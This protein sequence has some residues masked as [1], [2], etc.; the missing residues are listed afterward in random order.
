MVALSAAILLVTLSVSAFYFERAQ[1]I[2]FAVAISAAA[3]LVW[4]SGWWRTHRALAAA[5]AMNVLLVFAYL[6][7]LD[8][9][10]PVTVTATPHG[11]V[12]R[13]GDNTVALAVHPQS[14]NIGLY[15]GD[16]LRAPAHPVAGG[17]GADSPLDAVASWLRFAAPQPA[18]SH[19]RLTSPAGTAAPIHPGRGWSYNRRGELESGLN[20]PPLFIAGPG[21]TYRFSVDLM[22]GDGTQG[23]LVQVA[24]HRG[25]IL[26]IRSEQDRAYWAPWNGV[27]RGRM[28]LAWTGTHVP[29]LSLSLRPMVQRALRF[30]LPSVMLA[31]A[32]LLLVAPVY[33]LVR[34]LATAPM[35]LYPG[36]RRS[37]VPAGKL[38]PPARP[39]THREMVW[40][41]DLAA[42][43]VAVW[44]L[45][46]AALIAGR[47]VQPVPN[48]QDSVA[49]LFQAKILAA[50]RLW[51]PIPR[52][53]D[54]FLQSDLLMYHGHWFGKY[55]LGWPL[56]LAVGVKLG[57]AWLVNPVL[58]AGCLLL[59]YL[60]GTLIF[61][62]VV[63]LV[64]AAFAAS[65]PFL[66]F[67][68]GTFLA[69]TAALFFFLAAVYLLVL[70]HQREG[71]SRRLEWTLRGWTFL[72]PAGLMLGVAALTRQLDTIGLALPFAVLF[73]RRP[74]A[75]GWVAIAAAAPA[76]AGLVLNRA[77][78]GGFLTNP[79]A[80]V[81]PW[82]RIGFGRGVGDPAWHVTFT[83][84]LGFWNLA[85]NLELLQSNLFGWPYYITFALIAIPFITGRAG[86][87]DLILFAS[88][89]A[90]FGIYLAYFYSGAWEG[91]P[92][93]TYGA[94]PWLALLAARGVQELYLT[95]LRL[96]L[97]RPASRLAALTLPALLSLGLLAYTWSVFL[98]AERAS[99]ASLNRD[100]GIALRVQRAHLHH[101][102]VFERT[103]THGWWRYGQLLVENGPLLSGDV[104][105]ARDLGPEDRNLMRLYPGW[106]YYRLDGTRLT[107]IKG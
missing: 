65:S 26:L 62:R 98:P 2:A 106:A 32:L 50:G 94:I 34:L 82:D 11:Y 46:V 93:Y 74:L 97:G 84:A 53:P 64:G 17:F 87:W 25:Y 60:I 42:L 5:L 9:Q 58:L 68:A 101:A 39:G 91:F 3:A 99:M 67:F 1:P 16:L 92:R 69:H 38:A 31:L 79:Y 33:S 90:L 37:P 102:V 35:W 15:N 4:A 51:A 61:G 76:A 86:R 10:I 48:V 40:L 100:N 83:L 78:T 19:L 80:L 14:G 7:S 43:A 103:E 81:N 73:I 54:F 75:A 72:I 13:V 6:W 27:S 55:P 28:R 36:S 8:E 44:G 71:R 88:G 70:W 22:R 21:L 104:L 12:A 24:R 23:V 89:A 59:T 85:G 95:A 57:V 105:Y 52:Q 49:Y 30:F 47:I 29:H 107:P 96:P 18:W 56:V 77:L 63:A 41:C 66:L 45:V 20:A